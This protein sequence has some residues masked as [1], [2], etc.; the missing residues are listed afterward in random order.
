MINIQSFYK[1]IDMYNCNRKITI[2]CWPIKSNI[3]T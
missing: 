3:P 1:T 2:I